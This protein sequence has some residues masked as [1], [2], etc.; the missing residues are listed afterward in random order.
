[1]NIFKGGRICSF[2]PCIEQVQKTCSDLTKLGFTDIHTIESLR[3]ILCVKKYDMQNFNFNMD[4][5]PTGQR[6]KETTGQVDS[7]T[8]TVKESQPA[9][10]NDDECMKDVE[11]AEAAVSD[12]KEAHNKQ[13]Q[14]KSGAKKRPKKSNENESD[15][16]QDESSSDLDTPVQQNNPS[17]PVYTAKAI[18]LQ[19]GHTGFLT[20]AT[21][22]HK[23]FLI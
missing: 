19:P 23:D 14:G 20:F 15:S 16:D 13:K 6:S 2:S 7:T 5:K 12:R 11:S 22:L 1:M 3:R 9:K 10:I 21:L 4:W 17:A 18:N 8:S